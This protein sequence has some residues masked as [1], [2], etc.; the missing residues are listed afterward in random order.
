MKF[1]QN[2]HDHFVEFAFDGALLSEKEVFHQL[3]GNGAAAL[4]ALAG[5][6][7]GEGAQYGFGV[8]AVVL[9]ETSVLDGN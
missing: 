1:E 5:K 8:D 7:G 6:E 9:V 4:H 3:L 2:G